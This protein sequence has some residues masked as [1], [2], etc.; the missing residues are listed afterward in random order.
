MEQMHGH[1]LKDRKVDYKQLLR[2]IK[3]KTRKDRNRNT[4]YSRPQ[5]RGNTEPD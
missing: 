5:S 4:Y 2:A 1:V 3:R